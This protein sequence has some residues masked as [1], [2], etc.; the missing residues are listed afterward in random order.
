MIFVCLEKKV[1]Q[2][3][4]IRVEL[5]EEKCLLDLTGCQYFGP[6][7]GNILTDCSHHVVRIYLQSDSK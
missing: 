7:E 5:E 3:G 4:I 1:V 6:V 2:K